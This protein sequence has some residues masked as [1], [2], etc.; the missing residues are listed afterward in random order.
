MGLGQVEQA[1]CNEITIKM[2]T[3]SMVD[4]VLFA[5][6][7]QMWRTQITEMHE[8]SIVTRENSLEIAS[9]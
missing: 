3:Q 7:I 4:F 6:W 1:G 8:A 5:R 2:K 9:V